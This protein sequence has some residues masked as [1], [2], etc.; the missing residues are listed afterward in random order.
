MVMTHGLSRIIRIDQDDPEGQVIPMTTIIPDKG[1]VGSM[2]MTGLRPSI[3]GIPLISTKVLRVRKDS[4]VAQGY[5][6]RTK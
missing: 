2:R 4:V 1:P 5:L 6:G 3:P